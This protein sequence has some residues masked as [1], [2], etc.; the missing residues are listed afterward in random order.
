MA[1]KSGKKEDALY[2][3]Y[4]SF[5]IH[6]G[7]LPYKGAN[8]KKPKVTMDGLVNAIAQTYGIEVSKDFACSGLM[9]GEKLAGIR[10]LSKSLSMMPAGWVR[11]VARESAATTGKRMRIVLG[12]GG[13]GVGTG[14]YYSGMNQVC[15]LLPPDAG[16]LSHEFGHAVSGICR[17][18]GIDI[19]GAFRSLNKGNAYGGDSSAYNSDIFITMYAGS[20]IEEDVAE[21][22]SRCVFGYYDD[23]TRAEKA[24][25]KEKGK[26]KYKKAVYMRDLMNDLTGKKVFSWK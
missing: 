22:V 14:S 4:M 2:L 6:E 1:K 23:W 15:L 13:G 17:A 10:T 25:K 12:T 21:T 26:P 18:K 7:R 11:M 16:T 19:Y 20:D 3:H 8:A 24:E 9:R 5:G